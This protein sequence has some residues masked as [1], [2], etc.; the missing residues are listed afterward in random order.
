MTYQPQLPLGCTLVELE[1][2]GS[3]NDHAKMLAR[4]GALDGTVVW[5]HAQTAGRGRQGNSWTG[6][7]GNMYASVIVRPHARVQETGQLSFVAALALAETLKEF[8]PPSVDI[9]IKWPNDLLLNGK[10]CAG[11][12][13]ETE[14]VNG[15]HGVAW[16]VIGIGVN[17]KAAPENAACLHDFCAHD[18]EAGHVLEKLTARLMSLEKTWREN[19]FDCVRAGWLAHACNIG[20]LINVRLPR[21]TLQGRFI[22]IDGAGALE[23]ELQDGAR[24]MIA[25]GEVYA[26]T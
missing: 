6:F 8:L 10:K 21:E 22:G 24:R 14:T 5:T 2:V 15:A 12:L 11:I 9:G 17:V 25:S 7:S 26:Q 23:L 18:V 13:L 4:E 1:S 19:G 16:V 20:A 3:T